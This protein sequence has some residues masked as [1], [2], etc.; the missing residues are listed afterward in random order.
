MNLKELSKR[1]DKRSQY[2]WIETLDGYYS[3]RGETGKNLYKTDEH[4]TAEIV[5]KKLRGM[6]FSI[7]GDVPATREL[8]D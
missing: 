4:L 7:V 1:M 5:S 6:G 2:K 8:R 3:L